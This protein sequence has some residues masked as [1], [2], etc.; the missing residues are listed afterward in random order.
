VATTTDPDGLALTTTRTYYVDA[1]D[2]GSY[3]R[4]YTRLGPDESWTRY[5]YDNLGRTSLVESGWLDM[6][7]S[8]APGST[9]VTA[10]T[11][12]PVDGAD[13]QA[14]GDQSRPRTITE[15]VGGVTAAKTYFAYRTNV[16]GG[17]IQI[18][19]RCAT[20]SAAFGAPGN[21]RTVTTF[22]PAMPPRRAASG[23]SSTPTGA[24]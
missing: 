4:L 16:Q 15:Q 17:R 6:D 13:A 23:R 8:S 7:L 24:L 9:R 5:H 2:P 14:T 1:G 3:G 21:L 18:S 19:E 12:T 11:Y 22:Y 10:Y 20:P